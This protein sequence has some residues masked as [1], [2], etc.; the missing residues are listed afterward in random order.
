MSNK[1]SIEITKMPDLLLG[2]Q[3][4]AT[5]I[6]N[7]KIIL[8]GGFQCGLNT[9]MCPSIYRYNINPK[10]SFKRGFIK[11][12]Y[13][14]DISKGSW[15]KGD[16]LI[17]AP[18]QCSYSIVLG[19]KFYVW[20]GYSYTPLDEKELR[21]YKENNI[22]LPSKGGIYTY[23]DGICIYF[24]NNKLIQ[25]KID[26]SLIFSSNTK[27]INVPEE[28]KIYFFGGGYYNRL[29]TD[30]NI[31]FND[32]KVGCSFYSLSYDEN[33]NIIKNPIN[34]EERFKGTS[35]TNHCCF[36]V[37]NFIYVIGGLTTNKK[38]NTTKG[39]PEYSSLN[40]IDNWKYNLTTKKWSRIANIPMPISNFGGVNYK[41]KLLFFGGCRYNLSTIDNTIIN[42]KTIINNTLERKYNGISTVKNNFKNKDTQSST[43]NWYF[44]NMILEYDIINDNFQISENELPFNTSSPLLYNHEQKNII[45]MFPN[46]MNPI[47]LN[48]VYYGNHPSLFLKL[49]IS[50]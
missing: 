7:N 11:N 10:T 21:Y 13:I 36:K 6:L 38:I 19:N 33:F 37:N 8:A 9:S 46:E 22:K 12:I 48:D 1:L 15:T 16:E 30:T 34:Y 44:S 23:S 45:Y 41:N 18:R 28:K 25:E 42:N 35:R 26:N 5:G 39:Y 31:K 40:V 17:I 27:I 4:A 3:S 50:S 24:K 49:K 29:G 43:Y 20:G 32:I 14:Y 47:L 2:S